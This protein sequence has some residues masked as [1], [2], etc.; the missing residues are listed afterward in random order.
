MVSVLELETGRTT[1]VLCTGHEA[2]PSNHIARRPDQATQAVQ[3]TQHAGIH[4]RCRHAM[5]LSFS[6]LFVCK[7]YM[8]SPSPGS[9]VAFCGSEPTLH[10]RLKIWVWSFM[11]DVTP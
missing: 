7:Y 2:T 3:S 1:A 4:D 5:T 8:Y 6:S 10:M 9:S 11:P